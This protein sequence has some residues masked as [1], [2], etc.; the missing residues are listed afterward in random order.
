M[1]RYHPLL[2]ALH[3]LLAI[4]IVVG[5]VMGGQVLAQTPNSDPAKLFS[6]RMHMSLGMVIGALMLIRLVT[7]MFTAKPPHADI[8]HPAVNKLGQAAHWVLYALVFGMVASGIGISLL[9]GLPDIV[10]GGS[11]AALPADFSAF[12]PRAAHGVISTLLGLTILGHVAAALYH[13][14]V[15]RDGLFSRMS[16]GDRKTGPEA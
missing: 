16:F 8:G 4:M 14:F 10:F 15:R 9:A 13:Q 11:G 6:L 5:L 1:T 7:R 2:V 12:P 3:W